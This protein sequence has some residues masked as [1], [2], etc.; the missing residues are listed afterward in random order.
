MDTRIA[1][2]DDGQVA[3]EEVTLSR[4]TSGE[5]DVAIKAAAIC[6]SD[7][8]TVLGHRP[9]PT[10]TALGHEGVG[11]VLDADSDAADLR[12]TPL[13]S[14]DRVVFGL[15]S[16]CG[17]C[18]RCL[19]G[20]AMKCRSLIKYGHESVET[21]PYATGTLA[22]HVRLLPG[23]PVLRVPDDLTDLQVVSAGCAVATAAAIVSAVG[24]PGPLTPVL[25]YGAGAVG[26]YTIAM[27]ASLGCSVVVSEP[28]MERRALAE[29]IGAHSDDSKA[30]QYPI[31]IE[32]SGNAQAFS[33]A[34]GRAETGGRIV[35]AGSVS[36]GK[37]FAAFDP[38]LLVTRRLSLV[39]VHNYTAA[40][41]LW[42][43]DWL[44]RHAQKLRLD[45][46]VSPPYSLASVGQAFEDMRSGRYL[47]VLIQPTT[48]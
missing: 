33:E 42:G 29:E 8:H 16:A 39:G 22:T 14:G 9:T 38:A 21:P 36:P 31:V 20:L 5:I 6:G 27:L 41:F 2:F 1:I 24:S 48:S 30:A 12:G 28:S 47:R 40:E 35:A 45:K 15:F 23:V 18:D 34:I 19:D 4:R 17:A 37:T 44:R 26:A 11:Q 25:V 10:R 13:R 32:A 7:L 43:L 3:V 46:L